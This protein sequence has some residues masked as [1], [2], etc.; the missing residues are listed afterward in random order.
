MF[1]QTGRRDR[2]AGL[3]G[4]EEEEEEKGR[5][6]VVGGEGGCTDR[7]MSSLP[8]S[9]SEGSVQQGAGERRQSS[10]GCVL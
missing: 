8:S 2:E 1:L 4:G 6:G 5:G 3:R 10:E 7:L 9:Q